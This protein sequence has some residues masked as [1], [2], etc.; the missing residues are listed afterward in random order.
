[1]AA[2]TQVKHIPCQPSRGWYGLPSS[3]KASEKS[4]KNRS[5][6][7]VLQ[8]EHNPP[9]PLPLPHHQVYLRS[10]PLPVV[11]NARVPSDD[12][13]PAACAASRV[14]RQLG[15]STSY[16]WTSSGCLLR[17]S[18]RQDQLVHPTVLRVT[19]YRAQD[20]LTISVPACGVTP[21]LAYGHLT[22]S[23]PG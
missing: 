2:T 20:E 14:C 9:P 4:N 17:H 10:H 13:Q 3:A 1:M 11:R 15:N 6:L 18:Q 8:L 16:S 5:S 7:D 12:E 21:T 23:R 19:M 22:R